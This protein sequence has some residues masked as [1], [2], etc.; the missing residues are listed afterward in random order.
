[1]QYDLGPRQAIFIPDQTVAENQPFLFAVPAGA[2]GDPVYGAQ[3]TYS[4]VLSNGNPL[5]AGWLSFNPATAT[6]S[7]TPVPAS[8]ADY[9]LI[10]RAANPLGTTV[11]SNVFSVKVTLDPAR[12]LQRLYAQWAAAH[13]P[14]ATIANTGLEA[15]VWGPLANPDGDPSANLLEMLY[16]TDP[17]VYGL[18]PVTVGKL[19]G[20]QVTATFPW[21][22]GLPLDFIH[23][24]WS[25]D[26]QS[27]S[28]ANVGYVSFKDNNGQRWITATV[29]PESAEQKVLLRIA[30]GL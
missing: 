20:P 11:L 15:T 6:F 5:P 4:A 29:Y 26:L 13:F 18:P 17:L 1:F 8:N 12:A 28:R 30:V 27:W 16:G 24:E 22:Q 19:A 23:V 21:A 10:V 14:A 2:F 3:L 25:T 7:G 9:A